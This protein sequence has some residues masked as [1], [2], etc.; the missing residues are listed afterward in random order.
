MK[1]VNLFLL[2]HVTGEEKHQI[3]MKNN[4]ISKVFLFFQLNFQPEFGDY[5]VL[6]RKLK[7]LY[8]LQSVALPELKYPVQN[9]S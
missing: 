6:F 5:S 2:G 3:F 9:E 8:S 7:S 4:K 1:Y